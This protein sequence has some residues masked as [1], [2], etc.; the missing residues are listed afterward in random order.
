MPF[1]DSSSRPDLAAEREA[2]ALAWPA[3]VKRLTAIVGTKLTAYIA[4]T[5]DIRALDQWIEG[6]EPSGEV[7]ERLRFT[8]QVVRALSQHDSPRIVQAWLTGVNPELGDRVPLRVLRDEDLSTAAP[9]I[10]G[11]V[12]A[13]IA[14]A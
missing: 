5:K 12:S 1:S 6:A 10:L 7:E 3:I 9:E 8:Y 14:R 4:G 2:L 11:A 13:F